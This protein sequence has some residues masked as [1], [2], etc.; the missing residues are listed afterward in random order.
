MNNKNLH[1]LIILIS[2]I[3]AVLSS[4]G[5][6]D[7]IIE[8]VT[9]LKPISLNGGYY[10]FLSLEDTYLE[11]NEW[12]RLITPMFIHFSFSHL[13]FNCLWLYV[14]GSKIELYDGNIRFIALVIFSSIAANYS[15]HIFSGPGLF[16][17][18]SG[19]VYGMFGFCMILELESKNL[20]YG[21]PPAI[22]LFMLI[23]MLLGFLGILE[24]FGFGKV[25]N[26]AHL[27]GLIAGLI[28]G[29]VSK[30]ISM[31]KLKI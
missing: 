5:S 29:M 26:F 18:L 17:G 16:G 13:V 20:R 1:I 10:N 11:A 19:V 23:W 6:F 12:W 28:F 2:T 9:F 27:G 22:Y 31:I 4:F 25:A 21:L 30:Y 15:Q 8:F 7:V 24:I 3:V 14:L